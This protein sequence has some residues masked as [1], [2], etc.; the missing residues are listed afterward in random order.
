MQF[1]DLDI[2]EEVLTPQRYLE[3]CLELKS[4]HSR[5]TNEYNRPRE[6]I[7]AFFK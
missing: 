2:G 4:G 3:K 5:A 1:L 6:V 7:R